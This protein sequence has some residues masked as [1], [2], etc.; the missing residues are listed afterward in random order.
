[1]GTNIESLQPSRQETRQNGQA[2]T[3][4]KAELK[5]K[6]QHEQ[7]GIEGGPSFSSSSSTREGAGWFPCVSVAY[8]PPYVVVGDKEQ[9]QGQHQPGRKVSFDKYLEVRE[10]KKY[11]T[12]INP[13]KLWYSQDDISRFM[14]KQDAK[15]PEWGTSD[16]RIFNHR[17]RVLFHY[18]AMKE[19]GSV[20]MTKL[21][22]ISKEL[23]Q[24]SRLK[25]QKKGE[26]IA[27][28]IESD[29]EIGWSKSLFGSR[30]RIADFYVSSLLDMFSDAGL[31]LCKQPNT[32]I[33]AQ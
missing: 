32:A 33:P 16:A 30:S 18:S 13:D 8:P 7:T 25:A 21:A 14:D 10:Y 26:S 1:M 15:V 23:S 11:S 19:T 4:P 28:A 6:P 24:R 31:Q 3:D 17:R 12:R 5:T 27:N 9:Q 2:R 22:Q 20:D 29:P